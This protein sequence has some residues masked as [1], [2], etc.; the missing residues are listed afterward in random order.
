[1]RPWTNVTYAQAQAA[2]ASAG[3]RLCRTSRATACSSAAIS[4]DEWGLACSAGATCG[5]DRQAYPYACTYDAA[6]CNGQ[7]AARGA[8]A[9]TGSLA[10]CTTG[11]LDPTTG[12]KEAAYDLSGNVAEWTEDCRGR[13]TDGSG[14]RAFTLRGG[15]F[16]NIPQALRCDFMALVVA[17]DFAFGDTGFRCCSSC[18]PGQADCGGACVNLGSD[19]LNCGACGNACASG[20]CDNGF[21]R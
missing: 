12:A 13:L 18:G 21:C 6:T 20:R 10:T 17:E 19:A 7:D 2:C 5:A 14:R 11:D 4:A 15:S 16:S 1:M 8:A 9:P 3:M